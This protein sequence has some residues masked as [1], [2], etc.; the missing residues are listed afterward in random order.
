[1]RRS[2]GEVS[3]AGICRVNSLGRR[4]WSLEARQRI[5]AEAL[6]P[7]ASV[8]AVARRY[9]LNANLIFKWIRRAQ[10]G[11]PDGRRAPS[12]SDKSKH[13]EPMRF[14]PITVIDGISS[15]PPAPSDGLITDAIEPSAAPSPRGSG[16]KEAKRRGVIEIALPDGARISVDAEV[17]E[18][19]LRAVLSAMK[20]RR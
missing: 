12:N 20:D 5:V 19:A 18:A 9:G 14:I 16:R 15:A 6:A 2:E 7:D 10:N 8:A 4:F 11:W 3:G 13:L 17:D 1:M